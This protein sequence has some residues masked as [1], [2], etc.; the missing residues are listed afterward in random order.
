MENDAITKEDYNYLKAITQNKNT[1]QRKS[2]YYLYIA[3]KYLWNN[4]QP[5][6]ARGNLLKSLNEK[7]N[8]PAI[9]YY[10]VSFLPEKLIK[11]LYAYFK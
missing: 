2:D 9:F 10:F 4:Y 11:K 1:A 6:L 3:K 5:K 8:N 7:I